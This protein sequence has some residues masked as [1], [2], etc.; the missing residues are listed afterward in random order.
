MSTTLEFLP[1]DESELPVQKTFT[2]DKKYLFR[3]RENVSHDRIY[4]EIR[5][6]DDEILYTTRLTYGSNLIHATVDGLDIEEII[7]PYDIA[8]FSAGNDIE[9]MTIVPGNLTEKKL[10]VFTG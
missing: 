8:E 4:C 2:F 9:D 1:L 10:Y 3:F 6:T 7:M 5:N